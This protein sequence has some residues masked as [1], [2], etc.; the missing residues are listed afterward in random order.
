LRTE[1]TLPRDRERVRLY[2]TSMAYYLAMMEFGVREPK[3]ELELLPRAQ[4]AFKV[5]ESSASREHIKVSNDD[6]ETKRLVIGAFLWAYPHCLQGL[7]ENKEEW[8]LMIEKVRAMEP[9]KAVD[10]IFTEL[11]EEWDGVS[12]SLPREEGVS[13]AGMTAVPSCAQKGCPNKEVSVIQT[14]TIGSGDAG[15]I[16]FQI[17]ACAEHFSK[18]ETLCH[19]NGK[20]HTLLDDILP[21]E[22]INKK[23]LNARKEKYLIDRFRVA[24]R[25]NERDPE[26]QMMFHLLGDRGVQFATAFI[27]AYVEIARKYELTPSATTFV[28]SLS[29]IP[30][31]RAVLEAIDFGE[32]VFFTFQE[33]IESPYG[34]CHGF[35]FGIKSEDNFNYAKRFVSLSA[36]QLN[37]LREVMISPD[38]MT[39]GL[40]AFTESG[41]AIWT[42]SFEMPKDFDREHAKPILY[43]TQSWQHCQSGECG[44]G[45]PIC[46][47]CMKVNEWYYSVYANVLRL[48]AGD[49][50]VEDKTPEHE[51]RTI[52]SKRKQPDKEK[53]WKLREVEVQHEYRIVTMDALLKKATA[54][55][56]QNVVT[57]GSW[58]DRLE[59]EQIVYVKKRISM[60]KGRTLK[61]PR[62]R[63][64]I[65]AHGGDPEEGYTISVRD[66]E[67]RVPMK[68]ETLTKLVER[69]E[70]KGPE[71]R[72]KE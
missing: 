68:L 66:H 34:L 41:L 25:W 59:P 48:I 12:L 11:R 69:V 6:A 29:T 10:A 3:D 57:R 55:T 67:K 53:H 64:Y 62:Y 9:E 58:L 51:V 54:P 39:V 4:G 47:A 28:S 13:F 26:Y 44:D 61:D 18:I 72:R 33:P 2:A 16:E 52:T 38:T 8:N 17:A 45:K 60:K 5:L 22:L 21:K 19:D 24:Q 35:S 49:Y 37:K 15:P 30:F 63:K 70:A 46:A 7:K 50:A 56:K 40:D 14:V 36:A 23:A 43:M 71:Y 1:F 20:V 42:L 27:D 65:L 32:R 31:A